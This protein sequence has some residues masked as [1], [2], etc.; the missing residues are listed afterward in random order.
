MLEV[1]VGSAPVTRYRFVHSPESVT[2]GQSSTGE[3]LVYSP[4]SFEV[5]AISQDNRGTQQQLRIQVQNL[6]REAQAAIE[7]YEG[8][9]GSEVR[10]LI[11]HRSRLSR[12]KPAF[13]WVGEILQ[14]DSVQDSVSI[15]A[16][17]Y[18]LQART[19]PSN[20]VNRKRCRHE[21]AGPVCGYA[22]PASDPAYL[23]TCDFSLDGPNGCN[24]HGDSE[25]A[26]A[27]AFIVRIHPERFGAF[28][29]TPRRTGLGIG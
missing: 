1:E 18:S 14:T 10:V 24:V 4:G 9:V 2:F 15:T 12:G 28:P 16:G 7:L 25:D 17:Q 22:V 29:G 13:E 19:F 8:L 11:V 23:P 26:A 6:T 5:N 21:Y 27:G 20:K 3:P